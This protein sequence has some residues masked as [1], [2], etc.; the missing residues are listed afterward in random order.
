MEATQLVQR[1]EH[2]KDYLKKFSKYWSGLLCNFYSRL[3]SHE[4]SY[5]F[6]VD[7]HEVAF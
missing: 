4:I 6:S 5:E 2:S 1:K 3:G 7:I